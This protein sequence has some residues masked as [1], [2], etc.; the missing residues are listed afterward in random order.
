VWFPATVSC[1]HCRLTV[2]M[3]RIP[4]N[5]SHATANQVEKPR[6]ALMPE[7]V[8][9]ILAFQ[10]SLVAQSCQHSADEVAGQPLELG[11][12]P[13]SSIR[14][15]DPR[16]SGLA[17]NRT[18]RLRRLMSKEQTESS[19]PNSMSDDPPSSFQRSE[20]MSF[21]ARCWVLAVRL[22]RAGF[23]HRRHRHGQL[24]RPI[25]NR[26]LGGLKY[27]SYI[28]PFSQNRAQTVAIATAERSLS[29]T[30]RL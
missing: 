26:L 9:K 27:S 29:T 20:V 18:D 2:P 14:A 1:W 7:P 24:C 4:L 5:L 8:R 16:D 21:L 11:A 19:F 30:T 6:D 10:P 28:Y 15:P 23:G 13:G 17:L 25:L 3:P 22:G 12:A